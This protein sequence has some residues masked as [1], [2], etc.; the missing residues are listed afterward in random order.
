MDADE[1]DALDGTTGAAMLVDRD[2]RITAANGSCEVVFRCDP[3]EI[4]DRSLDHLVDAGFVDPDV[5]TKYDDVLSTLGTDDEQASF[6]TSISP[7]ESTDGFR[8]SVR[9][10]AIEDDG[11]IVGT[12]WLL[13]D[14]GTRHRYEDTIDSLHVA[15]R[16][17]MA[18]DSELEVFNITGS[19]ANGVLGFPGVGVRAYDPEE[20]VLQH[21]AF[22]GVVADID[23]RPPY[24]VEGTPHGRAFKTGETVVVEITDDEDDPYD[25]GVFSHVMYVPI[26]EYGVVS[27]GRIGGG[28]NDNDVRFAEIL[29]ENA[30]AA[31]RSVRHRDRLTA[32]REQ[33]RQQNDRLDRF[34]SAVSHDLRNPLTV[35]R[36][37]LDRYRE[38]GDESALDDVAWGHRRIGEIIDDVL[39]LARADGAV[40]ST[41]AVGLAPIARD[42]WAGVET[43]DLSLSVRTDATVDAD[44]GRLRRLFENLV[45]NV[46]EHAEGATT[47]RVGDVDDTPGFFV[48]DDGPGFPDDGVFE[49]GYTTAEDGTGFGLAIVSEL[50]EAH[51]W[52]V[53]A[54]E[55]ESGGARVDVHGVEYV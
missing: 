1:R 42:A 39:T 6:R 32:Q 43:G 36:G 33:L 24:D 12:R 48:A 14:L 29:V 2:G 3:S 5:T 23:S 38:T 31:L 22:G 7:R 54:N 46:V 21:V 11:T 52:A 37:G 51:G 9:V 55:S 28:F 45:R 53:A 26:G 30:A 47:I 49:H 44:P 35:A 13:R 19:A 4:T 40:D 16:D 15:T 50:A 20:H 27:I 17:L 10:T 18:A 25:R 41:E 34:A 8:Y